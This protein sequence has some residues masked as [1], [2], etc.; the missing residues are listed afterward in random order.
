MAE[1]FRRACRSGDMP[2]LGASDLAESLRRLCGYSIYSFQEELR[3]G[4]LTLRGGHRV[5]VAGTTVVREGK[6][7]GDPRS[8][9]PEPSPGARLSGLCAGSAEP[10]FPKWEKAAC[11]W[12]ALLQA[13]RQLYCVSW[14]GF[15]QMG[16]Q[17][18]CE[19]WLS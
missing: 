11:F 9:F 1:V 12:Q 5:G 2:T 4:F 19:R 8:F 15:S 17:D 18:W 3:E 6:I 16:K 10:F 13:E 7:T 14:H